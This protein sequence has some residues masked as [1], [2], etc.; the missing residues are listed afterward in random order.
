MLLAHTDAA[1][2]RAEQAEAKYRA[3]FENATEGIFQTTPE[4]RYLSANPALARIFGYDSP[5]EMIS[6]IHD[7]AWQTYVDPQRREELKQLLETRPLVQGFEAER[8]RKN[9]QR[10]WISINGRAVRDGNGKVLYYEGTNQDITPRKLAEMVLRQ[11]EEK[12]RSFFEFAPIGMALHNADGRYLQTNQTYQR[13]LGYSAEE[14]LSV[15]VRR[16]THAEDIKEAQELF[17]DMREG[18][19]GH[20]RREKRYWAKDGRLVWAHSSASAVR[21]ETGRLRYIISM[22][23]DVT[24]RKRADEELAR[25]QKFQKA[26]LDNI[27]DPAWLKDANGRFLACNEQLARLFGQSAERVLGKTVSDFVLWEADRLEHRDQAVLK[28]SKAVSGEERLIDAEGK[29]RWFEAIRTPVPDGFGGV[30]GTVGI[31]RDVTDRKWVE[32]LLQVQRDF[33]TFLASTND[34]PAAVEKLLKIALQTE[35]VDCGAVYLVEQNSGDFKLEGQQGLSSGF[36]QSAS[37][38]GRQ[39]VQM[40]IHG[41]LSNGQ[42][43]PMGAMVEQLKAEGLRALEIIPI[44]HAARVVAV[45]A[46]GSRV[47]Q[48]IPGRSCQA[49][50][51]IAAQ[52]GGAIA[53]IRAEQSLRANRQLLEKTLH[54]LHSAVFM[55]E[56]QTRAILECNPAATRMFGYG[57]AELLGQKMDLLQVD[58]T[59]A[60][61]FGKRMAKEAK[62]N[63]ETFEPFELQMRRKNGGD[64]PTENSLRPIRDETGTTVIWV[65]VIRDLTDLKRAEDDLRQSSRRLIAAQETERY[66][67]ARELHDG[68]NQVIA[69]AKM[70]LAKVAGSSKVNPASREILSRCSDLLVQA[71][72]ENRRIAYNLRPSDLDDLGLAAACRNFCKDV[73]ARTSLDLKCAISALPENLPEATELNLFRIAQEGVTNIEKHARARTARLQITLQ[74]KSLLLK[75]QDDGRGFHADTKKRNGKWR[76]IGLTNIRER[77]AALGGTCQVESAPKKGTCITVRVPLKKGK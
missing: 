54:S 53:R 43:A 34:L 69:S 47:G 21:D 11:S 22:V 60:T 77:A 5:E 6:I 4:G 9:G 42:G 19:L 1:H 45:L 17:S 62:N 14:L 28:S 26:I 25:T 49:I 12:F 36:A 51:A 63:H 65:S 39:A 10:F 75:I 67:V 44:Q 3:I 31:A 70:R 46:L 35:G 59:R 13:M 61:Q 7:L 76:G 32:S 27:P 52:A 37:Y 58:E 18:K 50:E 38:F 71:L 15:G 55:L 33:G 74:D 8:F 56:A 30:G 73:Q 66:R 64:F 41:V 29:V 20:Y 24:E 72:E 2:Q 57:R 23:E 16:L 40:D 48:E 68:V